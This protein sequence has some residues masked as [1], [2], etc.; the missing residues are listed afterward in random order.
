MAD[1]AKIHMAGHVSRTPHILLQPPN[2]SRICIGHDK[3]WKNP[4]HP[5]S[6]IIK[7]QAADFDAR[8]LCSAVDQQKVWM[9]CRLSCVSWSRF[10]RYSSTVQWP[11]KTNIDISRK[12][13]D[14]ARRY[15]PDRFGSQ[16]AG[17]NVACRSQG[18]TADRYEALDSLVAMRS[19]G[20]F[21]FFNRLGCCVRGSEKRS[22]TDVAVCSV[23]HKPSKQIELRSQ[24]LRAQAQENLWAELISLITYSTHFWR[25]Y[26][27]WIVRRISGHHIT[28]DFWIKNRIK[29]QPWIDHS[30]RASIVASQQFRVPIYIWSFGCLLP[31]LTQAVAGWWRGTL[32]VDSNWQRYSAAS[33]NLPEAMALDCKSH[34][35]VWQFFIGGS[36]VQGS[37]RWKFRNCLME[38]GQH[39]DQ[40]EE[41]GRWHQPRVNWHDTRAGN[42]M[43]W[44]KHKQSNLRN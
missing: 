43:Q 23:R 3:P 2:S 18:C 29:R 9:K 36:R 31:R 24:L 5:L 4:G 12:S 8:K 11:P 34:F 38:L 40:R 30:H 10:S 35:H 39:L 1:A 25:T 26:H 33:R 13:W 22:T 7:R 19:I 16:V 42:L 15:P 21:N 14:P 32:F 28:L 44:K 27:L 37:K 17:L 20:A 6:Q 41:D